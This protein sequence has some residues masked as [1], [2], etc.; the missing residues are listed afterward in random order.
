[1]SECGKILWIVSPFSVIIG[2]GVVIGLGWSFLGLQEARVRKAVDEA[3]GILFG[4]LVCSRLFYV[5]VHGFYYRSH[6][7][8]IPQVWLGGLS[9]VG[10]IWGA[11]LAW[12][13]IS[14]ISRRSPAFPV[15]RLV[16]LGSGI[17]IAVWAAC[18]FG[19]CAYGPNA[20]GAW[21]GVMARDE[22]GTF[23]PRFPTQLLGILI[24]LALVWILDRLPSRRRKLAP[25]I[26]AALGLA[27]LSLELFVLSFFRGDPSLSWLGLR[28]DA[29]GALSL[30]LVS[31]VIIFW[32]SRPHKAPHSR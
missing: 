7:I 25:G 5:A 2:V 18:W 13:L 6:L 8:E 17:A 10:G 28:L 22:W 27:G 30:L 15:D 1:M 11:L 31:L 20:N 9:G 24:I 12:W 3:L 29:W 14:A 21:W 32:L 4:C 23:A 26:L 19:G 16:Y